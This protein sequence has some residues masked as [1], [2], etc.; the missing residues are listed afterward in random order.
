M[1]N[2]KT[3]FWQRKKKLHFGLFCL[4]SSNYVN[5]VF[6][7]TNYTLGKLNKKAK[8]ENDK[9]ASSGIRTLD[10]SHDINLLL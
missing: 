2:E 8:C 1:Q 9:K 5:F 7:D 3:L 4:F 6:K 10:L